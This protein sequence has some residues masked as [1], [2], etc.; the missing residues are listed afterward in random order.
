MYKIYAVNI[1]EEAFAKCSGLKYVV[2]GEN[3]EVIG[4]KAFY[5]DKNL[6]KLKISNC[7]NLKKIGT[8]AFAGRGTR[9]MKEVVILPQVTEKCTK[10]LIQA[11]VKELV[12]GEIKN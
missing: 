11:G 1:K 12:K 2:F 3:L 4:K 8:E 5:A 6:Y 10:W 7:T 9:E